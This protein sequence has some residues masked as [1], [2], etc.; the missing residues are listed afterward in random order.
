[1]VPAWVVLQ[2]LVMPWYQRAG[3][4]LSLLLERPPGATRLEA[5]LDVLR[6]AFGEQAL[7]SVLML[8]VRPACNCLHALPAYLPACLPAHPLLACCLPARP[9]TARLLHAR[10]SPGYPHGTLPAGGLAGCSRPLV[11]RF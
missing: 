5:L 7:L 2:H 4:G 6:V 11:Y 1:V 10:R 9:P 8:L 3:V